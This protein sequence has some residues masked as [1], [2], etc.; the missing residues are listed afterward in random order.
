MEVSMPESVP[1]LLEFLRNIAA[2]AWGPV[3]VSFLLEH[4]AS[5]QQLQA[6]AKKWVVLALFVVLP[7]GAQALLQ[8]VPAE[9]FAEVEWLWNALALGF[10]GWLASQGANA[11]FNK[12]KVR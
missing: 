8:Y 5:F 4:I 12:H 2:G 10:A 9:A 7:V 1:T 6:E 11:L 3:L